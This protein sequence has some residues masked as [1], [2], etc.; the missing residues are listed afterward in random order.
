MIGCRSDP[1]PTQE[2]VEDHAVAAS[3]VQPAASTPPPFDSGDV[4][5]V[6]YS[7]QSGYEPPFR[8]GAQAVVDIGG[9]QGSPDQEFVNGGAYLA[10][11][12]LSG[13]GYALIDGTRVRFYADD[14]TEQSVVGRKGAGPEEFEQITS[15]CRTRGD[16]LIVND[17]M[18]GRISIV[19]GAGHFVRSLQVGH[20]ELPWGGACFDDG[21]FLELHTVQG[22]QGALAVRVI[23]RRVDGRIVDTLGE[24]AN[25][26]AS[27]YLRT[28]ASIVAQG[29]RYYH[30]DPQSGEIRVYDRAGRLVG[31]RRL[32]DAPE[33]ISSMDRAR[34]TP[35]SW[36]KRTND[37]ATR[38]KEADRLRLA[39]KPT[40]WPRFDRISV[41]P[42][43]RVWVQHYR[44]TP[45]S[46][47]A[48][49]VL[50][51]E[52]ATL[53]Q[54]RLPSPQG[55]GGGWPTGFSARGIV[56]RHEDPAGGI[57]LTVYPVE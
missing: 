7:L 15:I 3:Q 45:E 31:I 14:G 33:P 47:F 27:P 30:G 23:R 2:A 36:G 49:T 24:F 6:G 41:D 16:T 22:M 43:G 11:V 18:N 57:H 42:L 52:G 34:M 44:R 48:F 5:I 20:V 10:S 21:T 29:S 39:S 35:A 26:S 25:A 38:T 1:R 17:P 9:L 55:A 40:A 13:G 54:L 46:P 28:A 51:S 19:T 4:R 50:D 12:A 53:G 56:L 37:A 32:T 8:L